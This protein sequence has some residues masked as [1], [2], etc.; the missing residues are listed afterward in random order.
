MRGAVQFYVTETYLNTLGRA[1][2]NIPHLKF[3]SLFR[4]KIIAQIRENVL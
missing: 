2:V 4:Y 1:N 3:C